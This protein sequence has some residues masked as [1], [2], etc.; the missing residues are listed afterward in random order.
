MKQIR[1]LSE[2]AVLAIHDRLLA[3]HGGLEGVRDLGLFESAMGRPKN[4]AAYEKPTVFDLAALYAHGIAKNHPF[5][6]GNKRTAF[7]AAYT[8]LALNGHQLNAS[9][10]AA[11]SVT[12]ALAK[13]EIDSAGFSAWLK[14]E[15]VVL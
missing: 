7:M 1:W 3:E 14:E 10:E 2:I 6:D 8:F 12:V 5:N 11:V 4:A 9:E 13:G 15:S